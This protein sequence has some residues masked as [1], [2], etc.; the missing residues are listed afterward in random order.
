[1]ITTAYATSN[2]RSSS[3]SYKIIY[4]IYNMS[5]THLKQTVGW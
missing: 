5:K 3:S 2:N 1:M 4:I